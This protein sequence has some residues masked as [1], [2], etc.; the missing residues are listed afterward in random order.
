MNIELPVKEKAMELIKEHS[1]SIENA[2][3]Y[4]DETIR[5]IS[6]AAS[7]SAKIKNEHKEYFLNIKEELLNFKNK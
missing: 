1:G 7:I 2:L 3:S 6:W 4:V 5:I